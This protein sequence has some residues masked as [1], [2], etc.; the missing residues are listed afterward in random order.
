MCSP[1]LKSL[2]SSAALMQK[3]GSIY[4]I[5]FI[6]QIRLLLYTLHEPATES[7]SEASAGPE[8]GCHIGWGQLP[9]SNHLH[10]QSSIVY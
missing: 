1:L 10:F 2:S 8:L 9:S 3:V 4:Q 6:N 7:G 5:L